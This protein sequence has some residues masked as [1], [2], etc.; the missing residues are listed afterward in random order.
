MWGIGHGAW[1]GRNI[2]D[3]LIQEYLGHHKER[4]N[5]GTGN[6]TLE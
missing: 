5:E 6:F 3:E 1:S 2:T 4:S